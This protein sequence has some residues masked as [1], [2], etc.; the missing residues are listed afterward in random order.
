MS[1]DAYDIIKKALDLWQQNAMS[2]NDAGQ[3]NKNNFSLPINVLTPHGYYE[4]VDVVFD[5]QYGVLFDA[6]PYRKYR[7]QD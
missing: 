2:S 3:I 1:N 6:R 4:V 5:K 7:N